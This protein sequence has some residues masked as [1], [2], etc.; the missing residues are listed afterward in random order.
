MDL[1]EEYV[2]MCCGAGELQDLFG[3][4]TRWDSVG[5]VMLG[6]KGKGVTLSLGE[7][8][9]VVMQEG[10]TAWHYLHGGSKWIPRLDQLVEIVKDVAWGMYVHLEGP[11]GRERQVFFAGIMCVS[12]LNYWSDSAEKALLQ[13]VMRKYYTK[14]WRGSRWEPVGAGKIVGKFR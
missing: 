2:N 5:E 9:Q 8:L 4:K 11:R 14:V 7:R 12:D 6:G 1:S 13:F 10:F 3:A